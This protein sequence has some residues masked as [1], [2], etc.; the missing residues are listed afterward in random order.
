M[1]HAILKPKK[2]KNFHKSKVDGLQKLH[3]MACL[4]HDFLHSKGCHFTKWRLS[5]KFV[6]KLSFL[7]Q[8]RIGN[9]GSFFGFMHVSYGN[10]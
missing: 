9:R 7:F 1:L 5:Q 8:K 6:G 2:S 10:N 4:L 3:T